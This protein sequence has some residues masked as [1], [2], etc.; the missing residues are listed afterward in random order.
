ML[1]LHVKTFV[2]FGQVSGTADRKVLKDI[3]TLHPHHN[4]YNNKHWQI[5]NYITKQHMIR[6]SFSLHINTYQEGLALVR[7]VWDQFR[8]CKNWSWTLH[9]EEV[10]HWSETSMQGQTQN[11]IL[12]NSLQRELLPFSWLSVTG[13]VEG[14]GMVIFQQLTSPCRFLLL[15]YYWLSINSHPLW[16]W[17][18]AGRR[19]QFKENISCSQLVFM[20]VTIDSNC[21]KDTILSR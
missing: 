5:D 2:V 1:W 6:Q 14:L 12:L 15:I 11:S 16:H 19:C 8:L 13:L 18:M 20:S 17:K 7:L 10:K 4:G 3:F 9:K 21:D